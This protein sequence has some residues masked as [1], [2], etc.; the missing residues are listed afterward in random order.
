MPALLL[1]V[2]EKSYGGIEHNTQFF[3]ELLGDLLGKAE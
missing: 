1:H 2:R 3:P